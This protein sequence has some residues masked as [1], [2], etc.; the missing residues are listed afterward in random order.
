MKLQLGLP[1]Y[2]ASALRSGDRAE[3]KPPFFFGTDV[4]LN[5]QFSRLAHVIDSLLDDRDRDLEIPAY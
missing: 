4:S 5:D 2:P 3:P 1:T